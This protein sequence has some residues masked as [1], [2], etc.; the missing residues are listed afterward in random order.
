MSRSVSAEEERPT[1]RPRFEFL[2]SR[3]DHVQVD[4]RSNVTSTASDGAKI[5]WLRDLLPDSI[6]NARI[7]SYSYE[8]DWR[9]ADVKTSLRKCGEQL[10]NVLHQDRHSEKVSR[11]LGNVSSH[12]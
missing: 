7:A 11:L 9:K 8:S 5:L 4:G 10:L 2:P 1:K 3:Q 12:C 6:R